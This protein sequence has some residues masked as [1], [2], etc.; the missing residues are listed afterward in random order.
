[1]S[2]DRGNS[3]AQLTRIEAIDLEVEHRTFKRFRI[4]EE[5]PGSAKAEVIQKTCFRRGS[6]NIRVETRI[7]FSSSPDDFM[8]EAELTAYEGDEQF[9]SRTWERRVKRELL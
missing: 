5:D 4:G 1:V 6:W 2:S 9:F 3:D 8:L 7:S